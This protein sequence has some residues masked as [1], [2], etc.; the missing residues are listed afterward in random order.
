MDVQIF[1][2][3]INQELYDQAMSLIS[4]P[5]VKN[6]VLGT[7]S[8]NYFIRLFASDCDWAVN[9]DEDCFVFAEEEI[10]ALIEYMRL[11]GY[12]YCGMP[13]GGVVSVRQANPLI[14][15]GFFNVFN[16]KK[17]RENL[18]INALINADFRPEMEAK[19]PFH[20]M[21]LKYEYNFLEPYYRV[22]YWLL[23]NYRPLFLD[24]LDTEDGI[25][26]ELL[27]H[28]NCPFCWH[29][30]YAREYDEQKDRIDKIIK[31]AKNESYCYNYDKSTNAS[32]AKICS[33]R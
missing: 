33:T 24:A 15:N 32:T 14:P 16:V 8:D 12:D 1:T 11:K 13:D 19:T 22:F 4:L 20:L 3:S 6:R 7:T 30:W 10:P 29:T 21:R 27:S 5:Y 31:K 18:D 17:I 25:T 28:R 26:T 9:I 23:D 2:R